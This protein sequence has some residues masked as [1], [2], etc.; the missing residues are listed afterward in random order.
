MV[1][2]SL[3][4]PETGRPVFQ[5]RLRQG[6]PLLT[7][8]NTAGA[9]VAELGGDSVNGMGHLALSDAAGRQGVFLAAAPNGGSAYF[10]HPPTEALRLSLAT[11]ELGADVTLHARDE[12]EA[13]R[14]TS[15]ESSGALL[16]NDP[17]LPHSLVHIQAADGQGG[18][19]I[20]S[21]HQLG[22]ARIYVPAITLG[23]VRD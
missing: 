6:Q 5:V 4:H 15:G 1:L 9:V 22:K 18:M 12:R 21:Y 13:A 16:L 19:Q 3:P 11:E 7:L 20:G 14:L 23:E 2:F 17:N 8:F 10:Y